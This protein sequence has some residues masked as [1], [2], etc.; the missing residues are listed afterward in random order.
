MLRVAVRHPGASRA[1]LSVHSVHVVSYM[2]GVRSEL[3][4]ASRIGR[5]GL[6][7]SHMAAVQHYEVIFYALRN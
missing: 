7:D 2:L 5:M 3:V 1:Q 6:Y 4:V